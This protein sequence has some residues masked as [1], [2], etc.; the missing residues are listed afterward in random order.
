ML[1]PQVAVLFEEVLETIGGGIQLIEVGRSWMYLVSGPFQLL[2]LLPVCNEVNKSSTTCPC[3]HNGPELKWK[4]NK[5]SYH[6]ESYTVPGILHMML[7]NYASG[8]LCD[9]RYHVMCYYSCFS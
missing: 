3:C 7:H 6:L 8:K 1:G 5:V 9:F 4:F 2:S